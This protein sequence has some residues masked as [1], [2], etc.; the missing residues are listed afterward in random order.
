MKGIVPG[1]AYTV[2][3]AVECATVLHS[4]EAVDENQ[5][6]ATPEMKQLIKLRNP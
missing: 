3:D 1:H 2:L 4:D 6:E 5:A